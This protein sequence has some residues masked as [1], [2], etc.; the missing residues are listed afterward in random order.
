[1]V[2]QHAGL[3]GTRAGQHEDVG[4][5]A[6]VRDDAPLRGVVQALDDGPPGFRRGL[7]RQIRAIRQPAVQE[8]IPV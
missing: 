2:H 1:M 3:A 4:L 8:G 6:V 7:A 5:L